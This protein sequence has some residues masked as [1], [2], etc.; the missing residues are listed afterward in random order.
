[1]QA[2]DPVCKMTIDSETAAA[3][4]DHDGVTYYFCMVGCKD[5]FLSDP[6]NYLPKK[7]LLSWLKK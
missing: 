2:L 7:G 3:K 4:A 5:A 6:K 1:M